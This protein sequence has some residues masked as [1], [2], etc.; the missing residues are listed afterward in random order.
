[1]NGSAN[2]P[3]PPADKD[4]TEE[5]NRRSFWRALAGEM[6]VIR[7]EFRGVA[8]Q[9]LQHIDRVP[10]AVLAEMIPVWMEGTLIEVRADGIYQPAA[11]GEIICRHRFGEHEKIMVDQYACGRNLQVI[12]NQVS[13]ESDRVP[14]QVFQATKALFVRLCQQGLCHPAAAHGQEPVERRSVP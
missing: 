9:S 4:E 8:R 2:H 7:D 6:L 13:L 5:K 11:N 10:D 3:A 12:A 14:D 1:M